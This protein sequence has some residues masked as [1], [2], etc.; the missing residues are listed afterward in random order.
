MTYDTNTEQGAASRQR[1][2]AAEQFIAEL[3]ADYPEADNFELV[4]LYIAECRA[5][6]GDDDP[7][8]Q[9]RIF[10]GLQEW[11]RSKV[12]SAAGRTLNRARSPEERAHR[13]IE[14]RAEV[15]QQKAEIERRFALLEYRTTYGK[16]LGECTGAECKN[17]SHRYGDFFAALAA[18]MKPDETVGAHYTENQLQALALRHQ[19]IGPKAG[20]Q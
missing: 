18:K 8:W 12:F 15:E 16:P 13:A 10:D 9:D 17:L 20:Q 11:L 6:W 19:L 7:V 3:R 4:R 1:L 14:R 2:T 5:H